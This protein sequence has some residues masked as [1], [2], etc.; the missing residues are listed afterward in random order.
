MWYFSNAIGTQGAC[1]DR[2]N[3]SFDNDKCNFEGRDSSSLVS[4]PKRFFLCPTAR[5]CGVV[6]IFASTSSLTY[7]LSPNVLYDDEIMCKHE[8]RFPVSAGFN[9]LLQL[10]FVELQDDTLINVFVGNNFDTA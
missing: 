9:D 3:T 5:R 1:C 2:D 10:Q 4:D 8:I 7:S 6:T